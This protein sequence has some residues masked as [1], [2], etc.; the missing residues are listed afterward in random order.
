MRRWEESLAE[1]AGDI[2]RLVCL[3]YLDATEPMVEL[4]AKDQFVEEMRLRI[5]QHKLCR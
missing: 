2:E 4:L 1:L 3:A 5:R